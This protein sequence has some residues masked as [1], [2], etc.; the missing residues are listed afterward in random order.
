MPYYPNYYQQQ[1]NYQQG[2]QSIVWVS[3]EAGAKAYIVAPNSTVAL[4]DSEAP[5]V[6]LKSCDTSGMPSIKTLDYTIRDNAPNTSKLAPTSD[7][8]TKDDILSIEERINALEGKLERISHKK[9][10]KGGLNNEQHN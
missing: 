6:Y 9:K 8:L 5:V 1:Q 7:Y 3:G 2:T 4:F 10:N